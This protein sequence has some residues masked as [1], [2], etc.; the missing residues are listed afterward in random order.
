MLSGCAAGSSSDDSAPAPTT[1]TASTAASP[2]ASRLARPAQATPLPT[3]TAPAIATRAEVIARFGSK[4]PHEWGLET[5]GVVLRQKSRHA[6][7]TFDACGGPWGHK[8]DVGLI[9]VLRKH[10]VPATLFLNKRWIE[11]NPKVARQ[12]AED[13]LFDLQNHGTRHLPLSVSGRKGYAEQG[14]H[15]AGEVY[16]EVVGNIETLTR[17]TGTA[18]RFFRSGTA[19]MD[20]VAARIVRAVGMVPVNFSVNGDAGTTFTT[21]QIVTSMKDTGPGDIVIGHMNQPR[22]QTAEG[23]ARAIPEALE[24]G[25]TFALLKDVL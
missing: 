7:L 4:R 24:R 13:P 8:V 22:R 19:H 5:T 25:V 21:S 2:S 17:L 16:D 10:D 9:K 23:M 6:C 3:A 20:E 1:T 18:P 15:D 11:A 12:L 14:T